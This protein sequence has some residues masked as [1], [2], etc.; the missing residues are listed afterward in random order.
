VALKVSTDDELD[1]IHLATFRI[2]SEVGILVRPLAAIT[3]GL[4]R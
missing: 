3:D 2:L 1:A 4:I